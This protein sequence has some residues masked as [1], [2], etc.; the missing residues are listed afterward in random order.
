MKKLNLK[1]IS[2]KNFLLS[3]ILLV[4]VVGVAATVALG[5]ARSNSVTNTFEAGTVDTNIIEDK[6]DTNFNKK[7]K[8]AN[9]AE[10]KSDAYIRVRI[11]APDDISL[12]LSDSAAT[13]WSKADDG[14]YYYLYSVEPGEST[15]E[16]LSKLNVPENYK[17]SF[18][19]T[20]YQE[21]CIA[22]QISHYN[23]GA[24]KIPLATVKAAFDRATTDQTE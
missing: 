8:V 11:N 7:V 9:S 14:F 16:L 17:Q 18:D 15:T 2:K 10:S 22:S 21:S 3:V 23:E 19:V 1:S 24:A 13:A 5:M 20:V 4:A 6:V 12:E